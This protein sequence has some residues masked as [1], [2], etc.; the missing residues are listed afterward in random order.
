MER[1][2][3]QLRTYGFNTLNIVNKISILISSISNKYTMEICKNAALSGINIIYIINTFEPYISLQDLNPNIKIIFV[4][5][6]MQNQDFTILIT[7]N[8]NNI[9]NINNYTR[10]IN[11]KLI[12]LFPYNIGGDIFIDAGDH[13]IND[14]TDNVIDDITLKNIDNNGIVTTINKHNYQNEFIINFDNLEGDNLNNF[15]KN[16]NIEI[17]NNYSFKLKNFNIENFKFINGKSIYIKQPFNINYKMFD[18][19]DITKI[20]TFNDSNDYIISIFGSLIVSEIIK[21]ATNKFMPIYQWFNWEDNEL[22]KCNIINKNIHLLIIGAGAI[23]CEL[24]KNIALMNIASLKITIIDFD[25]IELSN[26]SRQFLFHDKHINKFKCE[27]LAEQIKKIN[28]N[29]NII[30]LPLK[31][32]HDNINYESMNLTAILLAVDNIDARKYMDTICLDLCIPMFDSGTDGLKGSTQPIIPFIT[33]TYSNSSD[34]INEI[35]YPVCTIKSFPYNNIHTI[36]WALEQYELLNSKYNNNYS[37]INIF[38]EFYYDNI[39][40]LLKEHPYDECINGILFWSQGRIKPIPIKYDNSNILHNDFHNLTTTIIN[41][42]ISYH[43]DNDI[44][45]KWIMIASNLRALNYNIEI[46]DLYTTKGI[47]NKIIPAVPTTTA[48]VAGLT[49]IELIKYLYGNDNIIY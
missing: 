26:L 2:D 32:G 20:K 34:P 21:I 36:Y 14:I 19:N 35:S 18:N 24:M 43:K 15:Y 44:C 7:D 12:I 31:V 37:I 17:I 38:N 29:I 30:A 5:N 4:N 33:E 13:L 6:Y 49:I 25:T 8:Y 47:V 42:N 39:N 9:Q 41:E 23:G 27:I 10:N 28:P 3:R 45:I 16:W 48:L 40:N 1:Y 22:N 11:S 46:I